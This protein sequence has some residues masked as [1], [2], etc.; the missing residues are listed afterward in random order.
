MEYEQ[1]TMALLDCEADT[2]EHYIT[3]RGEFANEIDE[4]NQQIGRLCD[5]M[6]NGKLVMGAVQASA[7]HDTLPPEY[8]PLFDVGQAT[9]TVAYRIAQSNERVVERLS[10]LQDEAKDKIRQNQHLP[11]IK[12]YLTDLSGKAEGINLTSGKA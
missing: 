10:Y 7:A 2:A 8:Y 5:E 12:K 1:A 11:V 4:L 6:P 9:R 3:Q